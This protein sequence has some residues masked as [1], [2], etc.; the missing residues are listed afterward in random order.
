MI[1][2]VTPPP[3]EVWRQYASANLTSFDLQNVWSGGAS[4]GVRVGNILYASWPLRGGRRLSSGSSGRWHA[5]GG[6]S[7]CVRIPLRVAAAPSFLVLE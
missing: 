2:I 3:L 5:G 6:S 1:K 4:H 7:R